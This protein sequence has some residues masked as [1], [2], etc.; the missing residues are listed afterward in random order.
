MPA[1]E[2]DLKPGQNK[3]LT[4]KAG[5]TVDELKK[6]PAVAKQLERFDELIKRSEENAKG[7]Q[8]GSWGYNSYVND[9][10]H[11]KAKKEEYI[12]GIIHAPLYMK[13][14]ESECSD[15]LQACRSV[16]K[17]IF[18]GYKDDVPA[19]FKGKPFDKRKPT[20][21]NVKTHEFLSDIFTAAGF[22]ATRSNSIFCSGNSG[23]ASGYGKI[24]IIFPKNGFAFNWSA[25]HKD[26]Y[27]TFTSGL[28]VSDLKHKLSSAGEDN[29]KDP[30]F[31]SN[32]AGEDLIYTIYDRARNVKWGLEGKSSPAATVM[33]DLATKVF[34]VAQEMRNSLW[35]HDGKPSLKVVE[36]FFDM[37]R[38][39]NTKPT[40]RAK[41]IKDA[42]MKKL[43]YY[44]SRK[45]KEMEPNQEEEKIDPKKASTFLRE[46]HKFDDTNFAAAIKSGH[47]ICIAGEYY[48]F[49][50]EAFRSVF[51]ESLLKGKK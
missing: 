42:E 40:V 14:I 15:A 37:V 5:V 43:G 16:K 44:F 24:Y 17:L 18:R 47:E 6:D 26:L 12:S 34:T 33:I 51:E 46:V 3:A 29:K 35:D 13:L 4:A 10:K 20:D 28:S 22:K 31:V 25:K 41:F 50:A 21:T 45:L 11:Y 2:K 19:A 36:K 27:S 39:L 32:D 9:V 49:S 38:Q 48:A 23:Q 8:K 1:N 7:A 30:T